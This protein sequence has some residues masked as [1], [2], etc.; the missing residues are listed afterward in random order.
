MG[1]FSAMAFGVADLIGEIVGQSGGVGVVPGR[2]RPF[3]ACP[4]VPYKQS[5][6]VA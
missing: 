3:T 2:Q 4:K 6:V 1:K 5:A